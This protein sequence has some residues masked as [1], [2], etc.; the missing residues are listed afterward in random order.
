MAGPRTAGYCSSC[1]RGVSIVR[2]EKSGLMNR[3]RSALNQADDDSNWICTKCGEPATRGFAPPPTEISPESDNPI[4]TENRDVEVTESI[5]TPP[6]SPAPIQA[7]PES[8]PSV[9]TP[10]Q[11]TVSQPETINCPSCEESI[12]ANSEECFFCKRPLVLTKQREAT[13]HL[14]NNPIPLSAESAKKQINCPTCSA[15]VILPS[16]EDDVSALTSPPAVMKLDDNPDRP[17]ISK[18]LCTQC[19]FELTYPKRLT[20]KNVDCPSCSANFSLP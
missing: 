13:C 9:P 10:A 20:G 12:P 18:A 7:F 1:N 14:C 4:S 3:M 6:D 17:E 2:P 16:V 11:A 8:T 5:V 19:Q 15:V